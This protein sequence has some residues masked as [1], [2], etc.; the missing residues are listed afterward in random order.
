MNVAGMLYDTF[1]NYTIAFIVTGGLQTLGGLSLLGI[2]CLQRY[3]MHS[4]NL[5]NKHS[6]SLDTELSVVTQNSREY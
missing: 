5:S 2:T 3:R 1:G 4:Y 6:Q